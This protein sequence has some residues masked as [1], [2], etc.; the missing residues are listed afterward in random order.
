MNKVNK[1]IIVGS[2]PAAYTAAIYASRANLSPIIMEGPTPGGQLTTTTDVENF[3]GY[4]DGVSGYD[5]VE[6]MKIQSERFGTEFLQETIVDISKEND[7]FTLSTLSGKEYYTEGVI[8]ATGASAKYLGIPYEET[9]L[10][11]G[12][13]VSACATCDGFFYGGKEVIVVGGGD[14]ALEEALFLS[15]ICSK[16]K[17]VVRGSKFRA[18]QINIDRINK[19]ENI[20]IH[21]NTVPKS[22]LGDSSKVLGLIV[23][24]EN[25]ESVLDASAIFVAIGHNPNSSF[26]KNIGVLTDEQGYIITKPKST[27]T[28]IEGLF[29]CGDV[30]DNKYRQA[31][32]ASGTGCMAALDLEKY[33]MFK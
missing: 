9:Y 5:L 21:M 16:V 22:V 17:L 14:T 8:V 27:E 1:C 10:L 23:D 13:G 33:L 15:N 7:V 28:N 31:I 32:T 30:A 20:E 12:G 6:D 18:S 19:I 3:P 11:N 29:A 24:V 2:G 4:P 26:V 25:N